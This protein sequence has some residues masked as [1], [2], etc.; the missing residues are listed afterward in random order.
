MSDMTTSFADREE[1]ISKVYDCM[2]AIYR[3]GDLARVEQH[4][5]DAPRINP[6]LQGKW[7]FDLNDVL[8]ERHDSS[9]ETLTKAEYGLFFNGGSLLSLA[10]NAQHAQR[11]DMIQLLLQYGAHPTHI[12][13]MQSL[14]EIEVCRLLVRPRDI[15]PLEVL[16]E[17]FRVA[18]SEVVQYLYECGIRMSRDEC[19]EVSRIVQDRAWKSK[20]F[21]E[22]FYLIGWMYDMS[23]RQASLLHN[24]NESVKQA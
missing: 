21:D 19:A 7:K 18:S 22:E 1:K 4:L 10:I 17:A 6:N 23:Y 15:L 16:K 24:K 2:M 3:T 5:R 11:L 9:I 13:L 12:A 20:N 14:E 8:K